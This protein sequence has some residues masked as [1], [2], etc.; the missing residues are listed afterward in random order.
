[1]ASLATELSKTDNLYCDIRLKGSC[2]H[3]DYF[4]VA[5]CRPSPPSKEG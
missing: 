2:H 4:H 5:Y 1:M 3:M